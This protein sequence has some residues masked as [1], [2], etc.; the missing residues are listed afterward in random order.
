MLSIP[1]P[2]PDNP[3]LS[4]PDAIRDTLRR[5]YESHYEAA[6]RYPHLIQEPIHHATLWSVNSSYY[7]MNGDLT[8]EEVQRA[9]S[10][11][12]L[13][14]MPFLYLPEETGLEAVVEYVLW[15]EARTRE[16]AEVEK[17][18]AWVQE[19]A[20][21]AAENGQGDLLQEAVDL[22]MAWVGLVKLDP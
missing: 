17:L 2:L 22:R 8:P 9:N 11:P 13:D 3:D 15:K 6:E 19:G 7:E 18:A 16:A 20:L 12:W 21:L 14:V 1:N 4:T 10:L 5:S